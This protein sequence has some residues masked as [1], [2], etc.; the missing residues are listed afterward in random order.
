MKLHANSYTQEQVALHIGGK[1]CTLLSTYT[2]SYTDP[3]TIRCKCGE[4]F[5]RSFQTIKNSK[6]CSC[7]K[8]ANKIVWT[9]DSV[10]SFVESRRGKLVSTAYTT[11]SAKLD[12]VCTKCGVT[13]SQSFK[14]FKRLNVSCT[15]KSC[16][17]KRGWTKNAKK[18]TMQEVRDFV[19]GTGVKLVSTTIGS[20]VDKLEFVCGCG[21]HYVQQYSVFRSR[22]VH[23]CPACAYKR[24]TGLTQE[25][26]DTLNDRRLL[27]DLHTNKKHNMAKISNDLGVSV[28]TV[29]NW[30]HKHSIVIHDYPKSNGERE[31]GDFLLSHLNPSDVILNDRSAIPPYHLDIYLPNHGAA[32]EYCGLYWHSEQA[33]RDKHYHVNK[34]NM[35]KDKGITLITLLED[36]WLDMPQLV[37][38]TLLH[39]LGISTQQTV[40]ARNT[41]VRRVDVIEKREF[42]NAYHIQ[43]NGRGSLGYGLYQGDELVAVVEFVNTPSGTL[44]NRYATKHKVV[45]GFSKLLTYYKTHHEWSVIYTFADK[46]WSNGLLYSNHG[47]T[48]THDIP[49]DYY[50]IKH[51]KRFH[52]F[53]FRHKHLASRLKIYDPTLSEWENC[54]ANGLTRLWDCGK[55]RFIMTNTQK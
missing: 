5:Y 37:Q 44:L 12:F 50:Y 41:I 49:P 43:G 26:I 10:R 22:K 18:V 1:Q 25:Q 23:E 21:N 52:K 36:E 13:F 19:R 45:G 20:I 46:R 31:V 51:G 3:L 17:Q 24:T 55:M 42:L 7:N 35:C 14:D 27:E 39:K 30:F 47:F 16:S 9:I 28:Q 15:C 53:M 54:R 29:C 34:Y 11:T 38:N 6:S 40:Y 33:G 8:C 48:H 2:G 32:I 4:V